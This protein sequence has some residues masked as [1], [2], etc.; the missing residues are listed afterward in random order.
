MKCKETRMQYDHKSW[1]KLIK[2]TIISGLAISNNNVVYLK[3]KKGKERNVYFYFIVSNKFESFYKYKI[4]FVESISLFQFNLTIEI[5]FI[6]K[7]FINL[8]NTHIYSRLHDKKKTKL[9]VCS[10]KNPHFDEI[11]RNVNLF[12]IVPNNQTLIKSCATYILQQTVIADNVRLL[13]KHKQ[14]RRSNINK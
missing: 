14:Q 13:R 10:Y 5:V 9:C 8:N 2:H 7:T 12:I 1:K 6:M 11:Q 3:R 4:I